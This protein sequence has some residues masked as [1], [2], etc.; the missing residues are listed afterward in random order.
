MMIHTTRLGHH[1]IRFFALV[2]GLN[3]PECL[4]RSCPP[5][6]LDLAKTLEYDRNA[7]T[8]PRIMDKMMSNH[9][10]CLY[11]IAGYSNNNKNAA[12]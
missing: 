9:S 5:T 8:S 2:F 6:W 1:G 11:A 12:N 10:A 4:S 3:F 7:I